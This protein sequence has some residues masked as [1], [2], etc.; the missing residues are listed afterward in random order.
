[1]KDIGSP[2]F[3]IYE[4]S[5]ASIPRMTPKKEPGRVVTIAD[6][7]DDAAT[8][9]KRGT[10]KLRVMG[11]TTVVNIASHNIRYEIV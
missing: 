10:L 4:Y 3:G 1:M 11:Q 9:L 2:S 8:R 5:I 6:F 7:D